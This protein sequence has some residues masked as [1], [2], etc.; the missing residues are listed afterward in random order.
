MLPG[1]ISFCL[2]RRPLVLI[3]FA[4]FLAVGYAAFT[5][6]NIEAYPEHDHSGD[7]Q[8][9]VY[10]ALR[11]GGEIEIDGE[12]HPLD[13]DRVVRVS[14]GTSR[15]VFPG[16]EGIRLVAIGGVPGKAYEV[17]D[18]TKLGSPDPAAAPN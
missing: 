17:R 7:G 6:L 12:R 1:L 5:A 11:G 14:A 9:E 8:E 4:A 18:S 3:S 16:D 15:K 13:P 2:S 10:L